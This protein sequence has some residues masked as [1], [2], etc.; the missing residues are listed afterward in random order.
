MRNLDQLLSESYSAAAVEKYARFTPD[1]KAI[2]ALFDSGEAAQFVAGQAP[3][4]CIIQNTVWAAFLLEHTDYPVHVVVGDLFIGDVHVYGS[5][6]KK[7]N[8]EIRSSMITRTSTGTVTAGCH[9]AT[10]LVT[11]P[12]WRLAVALW[13]M[14]SSKTTYKLK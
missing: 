5:E 7:A 6:M 4:N 8:T 9:L 12:Y 14:R 1:D 13:H 10:L 11:L 2:K 3:G